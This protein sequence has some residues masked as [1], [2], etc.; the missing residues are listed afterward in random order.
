MTNEDYRKLYNLLRQFQLEDTKIGG[1]TYNACDRVL[2]KLFP[3]YY[4]Q[5]QEQER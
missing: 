4:N 1:K 5:V 3:H 2:S